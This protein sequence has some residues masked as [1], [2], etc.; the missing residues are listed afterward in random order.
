MKDNNYNGWKNYET[1]LTALWIDNDYGSYLTRC[2]MAEEIKQ[3]YELEDEQVYYLSLKLKEWIEE[4]NP[5]REQASLF[6]D[7]LNAAFMEV[8][9]YEIA[10]NFLSE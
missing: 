4:L 5:I 9:W 7:L 3:E 8:D 2:E 1:W 10:E 6:T